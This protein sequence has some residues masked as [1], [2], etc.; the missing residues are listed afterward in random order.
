MD[1]RQVVWQG[2]TVGLLGHSSP[3]LLASPDAWL[4]CVAT[5]HCDRVL[6]A[7]APL[8]CLRRNC[9]EAQEGEGEEQTS[10]KRQWV[11][12]D[13]SVREKIEFFSRLFGQPRS[14]REWRI[15]TLLD[16]TGLADFADRPA[17][18]LSG[19]MR[20]KL[21][22][23][24][25]LIHDPDLLILDEPTTG[26]EEAFIAL[27][28]ERQRSGYQT[29]KITPHRT[30]GAEPV[31]VARNL[32]CRRACSWAYK[33]PAVR[34]ERHFRTR[35][36]WLYVAILLALFRAHGSAEPGSA[37]PVVPPCN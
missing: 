3:T 14:E 26:V 8:G 24:C 35:A 5:C 6:P 7:V 32:T 18:K 29:L 30:L 28:P 16:N 9:A 27:L 36:R 20:Q 34:H 1:N 19:G 13:L 22:L 33:R 31:I 10:N 37:R 2:P 11:Y 23:C 21:G 25:S 17:K 15:A 12:P 4:R